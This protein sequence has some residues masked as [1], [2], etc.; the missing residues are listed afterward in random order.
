MIKNTPKY[1]IPKGKLGFSDLPQTNWWKCR[2]CSKDHVF[3]V[4][5]EFGG[6]NILGSCQN[7]RRE[8]KS[9]EREKTR[10]MSWNW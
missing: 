8:K 5:F 1:T 10:E 4:G 7:P 2:S 9:Y 6:F 3:G